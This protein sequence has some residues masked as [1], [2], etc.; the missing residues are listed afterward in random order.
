MSHRIWDTT[1]D[2]KTVVF[3][4]APQSDITP[5]EL[6]LCQPVFSTRIDSGSKGHSIVD[7]PA[8]AQRHFTKAE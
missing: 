1:P 4:W 6:A 7:L 2:G 3:E 5:Y 8:E